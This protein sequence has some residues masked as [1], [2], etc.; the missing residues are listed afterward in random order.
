MDDLGLCSAFLSRPA[1]RH[2]APRVRA[3]TLQRDDDSEIT[4]SLSCSCSRLPLSPCWPP[5][6]CVQGASHPGGNAVNGDSGGVWGL[7]GLHCAHRLSPPLVHPQASCQPQEGP[8]RHQQGACA[9]ARAHAPV[10]AACELCACHC[11]SHA[12][13][14]NPFFPLSAQ[15][16]SCKDY[17]HVLG[18]DLGHVV[19]QGVFGCALE[20]YLSSMSTQVACKHASVAMSVR[21]GFLSMMGWTDVCGC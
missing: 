13:I 6:T 2:T 19:F 8:S 15:P 4:H 9:R 7:S 1:R 21:K 14:A 16:L 18:I 3:W 12:R 5:N 20:L 11:C 17:L 10:G